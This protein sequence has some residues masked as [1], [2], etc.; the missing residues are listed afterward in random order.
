[1]KYILLIIAIVAC[2]NFSDAQNCQ[3][4]FC[5]Q[6]ALSPCNSDIYNGG[7]GAPKKVETASTLICPS[8]YYCGNNP[9]QNASNPDSPL[10]VCLPLANVGQR[11]IQSSISC[12]PGLTCYPAAAPESREEV[13]VIE[14]EVTLPSASIYTCQIT[15]SAT[16]GEKCSVNTDCVSYPT[17][18]LCDPEKKVCVPL[19]NSKKPTD[20]TSQVH[21][22]PNEYCNQTTNC[23][24]RLAIGAD[25][26]ELP[27]SCA[28]NSVCAA[29]LNNA[30]SSCVALFSRSNGQPCTTI[31]ATF[32]AIVDS[33]DI[34]QNTYCSYS[35][36]NTSYICQQPPAPVT[37]SNCSQD[38]C[39][40]SEVCT[41]TADN[42]GGVCISQLPTDAS[43]CK[44]KASAYFDCL[45]QYNCFSENAYI[46]RSC[47]FVNCKAKLCDYMGA[48]HSKDPSSSCFTGTDNFATIGFCGSMVPGSSSI[49]MPS[50]I[51]MIVTLI[52]GTILF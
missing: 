24:P 10:K 30:N 23:L 40:S 28:I 20:C 41:C 38:A 45:A 44:T 15:H 26:T 37:T 8:Q 6:G 52:I 16:V 42:S 17:G 27:S 1:M 51:L 12:I 2:V 5:Q 29:N 49:T 9:F 22:K 7:G 39:S 11:C 31:D 21:C 18:L 32:G 19:I 50:M 4:L 48:C 3:K 13:R 47:G 46:P 35:A 25:C 43:S 34:S 33:C 14:E 36:I